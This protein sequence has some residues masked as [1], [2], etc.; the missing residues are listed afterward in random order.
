M[1]QRTQR[2]QSA[3]LLLA[4]LLLV[5][6]L[7]SLVLSF[8]PQDL[9][10]LKGRDESSEVPRKLE[11]VLEN[12]AAKEIAVTISEEELNRWISSRLQGQ[13]TGPL[14]NS[15]SY[16]G[17]WFRLKEG[18]I[19]IIIE[20]EAFGRPHTVAATFEIE[21]LEEGSGSSTQIH[22]RGGRLGQLPVPQGY[23]HLVRS[24]YLA[25]AEALQMEVNSLTTLLGGQVSLSIQE[26]SLVL[27]P[28]PNF[29][30]A[31]ITP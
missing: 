24:S 11:R 14:Q 16:Q 31:L 26:D 27:R 2:L 1:S 28:R 20:R 12:A 10:D 7:T 8:L 4:V 29:D 22:W 13:Q 21:Q 18:G 9:S 17:T 5:L 15:V 23:L 3:V 19:D 25:L 30:N 6:L